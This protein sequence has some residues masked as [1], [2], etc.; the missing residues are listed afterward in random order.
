MLSKIVYEYLLPTKRFALF[1]LQPIHH[2]LI[3]WG[4][5][6]VIFSKA[7]L[8]STI[9]HHHKWIS[10]R[11]VQ[12]GGGITLKKYLL[13]IS[14]SRVWRLSPEDKGC[15][16]SESFQLWLKSPKKGT[17]LVSWAYSLLVDSA[18]ECDLALLF[19]DL[20]QCEK[21]SGMKQPFRNC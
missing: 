15:L 20:K 21:L 7:C 1:A 17:K 3:H 11:T 8:Y 2:L 6:A 10:C 19:G 5:K 18:Q 9:I 13:S 14:G 4:G 16:I 12:W